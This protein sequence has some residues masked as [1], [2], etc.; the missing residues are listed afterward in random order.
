MI[1]I[2]IKKHH[3]FKTRKDKLKN[4]YIIDFQIYNFIYLKSYD[5]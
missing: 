2:N 5:F 1:L 3:K 4:K